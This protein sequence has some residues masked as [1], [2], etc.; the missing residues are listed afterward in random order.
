MHT[1][2]VMQPGCLLCATTQVLAVPFVGIPR[3]N[4]LWPQKH[5]LIEA[6]LPLNAL[7]LLAGF[8]KDLIIIPVRVARLQLKG[9]SVVLTQ[10][11]CH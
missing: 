4:T 2:L 10:Q 1:M 3:L 5:A 9:S 11:Y 8:V 7:N 6:A